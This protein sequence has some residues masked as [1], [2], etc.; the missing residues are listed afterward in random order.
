MSDNSSIQNSLF[1]AM[2]IFSESATANSGAT[3]TIEGQITSIQDQAAGVYSVDYLGS[4][5][6]AHSNSNAT[7]S[8]GDNV[9]ILV[10]DGDFTKEKVI[11]SL[12][13]ASAGAYTNDIENNKNYYEISD[14]L[15]DSNIDVIKLSSYDTIKPNSNKINITQ[16]EASTF[17]SLINGY[18]KDYRIFK[19]SL[20]AKTALA[21]EQQCKGDYGICLNIPIKESAETGQGAQ[22]ETWKTVYLETAT[23]VGTPYRL[24][25]WTPQ[26]IYFR[27][28]EQYSY[29]KTRVPY[30]SYF[31][32]DFSQDS[33]KTNIFD[34]QLKDICLK[35]VNEMTVEETTGYSLSLKASEGE[36]YSTFYQNTKTIT[37]TLKVNG[38]TTSLKNS[39]IYW[40]VEDTEIKSDSEYYST[41]GGY[42]WKCL[43]NKTNVTYNSDGT[44]TFNYITTIQTHEVERADVRAATRF[45]CVIIYNKSVLSSIITLKNLSVKESLSLTSSKNLT[46]QN[47]IT[48]IAADPD[49]TYM[50]DTG[51][52]NLSALVYYEGVTDK[53][54]NRSK[55]LYSWARYDKDGNFINDSS[56]FFSSIVTN[57]MTTID[58]KPYFVTQISFPVNKVEELNTVYCTAK[59]VY[60]DKSSNRYEEQIGT[61]KIGI[62]TSTEYDLNLNIHG[63]NVIYK[64]DTNG[65]SPTV[66]SY[67]GPSSSK[68]EEI[69]PLTYS[70][71][72]ADGEELS[73]VEY[74]FVKYSWKVP[75]STI[76]LFSLGSS[77]TPTREEDNYY[78]FEGY[79]KSFNLN[80]KI[81]N[82]FNIS[83]T[84]QSI[85]LTITF[86]GETF[87]K[88][89]SISFLKEGLSGSNGTS[90][91]AVLVSGGTKAEDSA[92]AAYGTLNASG[93]A[94]K[95]K[96]LYNSNSKKLYRHNYNDNSLEDWDS[97]QKQIFPQVWRDSSLL[98][99]NTHYD[100][101]YS[102]FDEK[103]TEPCFEIRK[104]DVG[105]CLLSL[106]E[107]PVEDSCNIVQAKITVND[108]NSSVAQA[109]QIIYA[110]YPI[111][112]TIVN[113]ETKIIPSL[114]GGFS[115]V[116]YASDGTNPSYDETNNFILNDDEVVKNEVDSLEGYFNIIWKATNHLGIYSLNEDGVAV[117]TKKAEVEDVTSIK[118]KP[119]N[120]YDDGDSKNFVKTT[121]VF[122][123]EREG[124]LNTK[125]EALLQKNEEITKKIEAE[126]NNLNYIKNII[127]A[128]NEK[129]GGWYSSL[130]V[131]KKLLERETN[132]EYAL[133]KIQD[134]IIPE[135]Q[136]YLKM[137]KLYGDKKSVI[138]E[139]TAIIQKEVSNLNEK[140][141]EA[142][143]IL[144]KLDGTKGASAEDL[145]SFDKIE[146]S[147][148]ELEDLKTKLG[149]EITNVLKIDVDRINEQI[150][151]YNV[152]YNL[153]QLQSYKSQLEEYKKIKD[154]LNLIIEEIPDTAFARYIEFKRILSVIEREFNDGVSYDF[155]FKKL[156][157]IEN[158]FYSIAVVNEDHT[159]ELRSSVLNEYNLN[160]EEYKKNIEDN[161]NKINIIDN[162]LGTKNYTIT[163][164][165]PIV[166]YF[167]RYEMSNINAWDGN[168]IETGDGS[169]LLAPQVGAGLK[170][171]DNTFT[172]L[173]MGIK[174]V[175]S[176]DTASL[177]SQVGLFGYN[178]GNQSIKLDA[179]TGASIFGAAGSGGQIIIDPSSSAGSGLIYS[180]NY[181][182]NYN[183]TTGMPQSYSTTNENSA[184]MLINFSEPSIKFGTGYFKVDKNGNLHAGGGGEGDVGG[185]NIYNTTLQSGNYKAS[186]NGICL[187]AAN[188]S[189]IFG[190]SKG[191]I[192]SGSHSSLT[193]TQNGFYL[194]QEGLSIGSK[195]KI[196]SD[197][198]MYLG[199]GAVNGTGKHW[200]INGGNESYIKYGNEGQSNSVYLAT[201]HISLGS[202]FYVNASDGSMRL[203]NGAV[204]NTG[205]H[206][207][208]NTS[209]DNSYI[210]YGTTSFNDTNGV[211]LGTDG[212]RL[213]DDFSVDNG[214]SLTATDGKI[215]GWTISKTTL[216]AGNI[217]LN[218][219]GSITKTGG[220]SW[221]I[222]TSGVATFNRLIANNS[223]SIGGWTIGSST[224]SGGNITLNSN[225][226][227][228]GSNWSI[229]TGGVASFTNVIITGNGASAL[230]S[231]GSSMNWGN[232][233]SVSTAGKLTANSAALHGTVTAVAGNIGGCSISNGSLDVSRGH[234]SSCNMENL[235]LNGTKVSWTEISAID[236]LSIVRWG[237][238]GEADSG[239]NPNNVVA[240]GVASTSVSH[241]LTANTTTGKVSGSISVDIDL[242]TRT[243]KDGLMAGL[244]Y[245]YKR[246]TYQVCG[247][248][249]SDVD[250]I[251]AD[252]T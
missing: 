50:K 35:I 58:E 42:G 212:I 80:Y 9:Y 89:A 94:Q 238:W 146:I 245:K 81:A 64:Y 26:E 122:N 46:T 20:S 77:M 252:K 130:N 165:R 25:V 70:V 31:C 61:A 67:N 169:Y 32:Y 197:G 219:N 41:Y 123:S 205:K 121:L 8:V 128:Y 196:T 173:V 156:Q 246:R 157:L 68:I 181:W 105:G 222:D 187:D 217:T 16:H 75:K 176:G 45:K 55:V 112:L 195:A 148:T 124:E 161:Q 140:I 19:L 6:D 116:M 135:L 24:L 37:P 103:V 59:Y 206:W 84:K 147:A 227:M 2:K 233:F 177:T 194:S 142:L 152:E 154:D 69:V 106:K 175:T 225:G 191:E 7:Y 247:S 36:Y 108:G 240:T 210:A 243:Y 220:Y 215:G 54:S 21:V 178:K 174:N 3:I 10:P 184:G 5:F 71:T 228:S 96:F 118:I 92:S 98:E 179:R 143:V 73:D 162:I 216:A 172:G 202:K 237:Y 33:D 18:L 211:Y 166:L 38:K 44:K 78:Y 201:D 230:S 29:D 218:S 72:R 95:L 66:S 126:D 86:Q 249:S 193:N 100:V 39:S 102:M 76:S 248:D 101:E 198:T 180:S 43:N 209:G 229:S 17:G 188:D 171:S 28:D 91:S 119:D 204:A 168:K 213:G 12:I 93:V 151:N 134:S 144:R 27:I 63:D 22:V 244:K 13:S 48:T 120:K 232:G 164:I 185:W 87:E 226:S 82:R 200:E 125:K 170:E 224:L 153:L 15:I 234:I 223:G 182:K 250:W 132:A 49:N 137:Q 221:S 51:F 60:I 167:N 190:S 158:L 30:L 160:I 79:G 242:K 186:K 14:N 183:K 192:Y 11:L 159:V 1:E 133:Q 136:D 236:N 149:Q 62:A 145:L 52:V 47:G 34:I 4:V 208:V 138:E 90:Y 155:L 231:S 199:S 56:D 23:F 131:I 189:I 85:N 53:D 109:E 214:G 57:K 99:Y 251:T 104:T 163:H 127:S 65:N 239:G 207:N 40:F 110:Y 139:A 203:G 141:V 241:S 129:V 114:D 235:Y 97:V 113:Q 117:G 150:G 88:S 83:R 74:Q 107:P 111:E 115:E